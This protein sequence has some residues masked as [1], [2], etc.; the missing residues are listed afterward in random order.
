MIFFVKKIRVQYK[1]YDRNFVVLAI[2]LF[3]FNVY[4]KT[5]FQGIFERLKEI[6][7]ILKMPII[8]SDL[9]S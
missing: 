6:M 9:H 4:G 5:K 7:I 1:N 8:L 3:F 2:D